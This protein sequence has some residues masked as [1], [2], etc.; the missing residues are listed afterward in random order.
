LFISNKNISVEYDCNNFVLKIRSVKFGK[1]P[2]L[3]ILWNIL[4]KLLNFDIEYINVLIYKIH[5]FINLNRY[6]VRNIILI[7]W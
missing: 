1:F 5:N 2:L 7:Q 3:I 6:D 4:L